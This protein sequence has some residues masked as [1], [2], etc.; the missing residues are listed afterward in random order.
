MITKYVSKI[1]LHD[2]TITWNNDVEVGMMVDVV[3]NIS[4]VYDL[5]KLT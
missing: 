1:N 2:Y 5:N 3:Q 4:Y